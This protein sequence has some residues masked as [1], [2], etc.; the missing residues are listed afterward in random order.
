MGLG[1]KRR[2]LKDRDQPRICIPIIE[3]SL[4]KAQNSVHQ[5]SKIADLIELRIDYLKTPQIP[6]FLNAREKPFII[7]YRR[8]EE[9][10]KHEINDKRRLEILE[11]AILQGFDYVDVE[12]RSKSF[13]LHHLISHRG[14]TKIIL[15]YHDFQKTPSIN[16]LRRL[17]DQMI[18]WKADVIK[19][20]TLAQSWEDNLR[21]LSLIPYSKQRNQEILAFCMGKKGKISRILSPLIGGA[22]TYASLNRGKVSAPGQLTAYEMRE[23]WER[24]R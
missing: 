5:A 3:N 10:G 8:R 9:G 18:K 17:F 21:V 16:E 13:L 15:S 1:L 14:E 6:T 23:I 19:M 20:V 2:S 11:E 4:S 12:V 22:W 24:L 7:T